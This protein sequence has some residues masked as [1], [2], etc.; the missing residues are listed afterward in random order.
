MII[1][2]RKKYEHVNPLQLNLF[3]CIGSQS[4]KGLNLISAPTLLNS[5]APK[6]QIDSFGTFKQYFKT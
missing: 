5:L 1:F 2:Q 4:N 3:V 6:L